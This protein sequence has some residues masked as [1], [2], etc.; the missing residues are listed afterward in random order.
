MPSY[1]VQHIT[2]RCDR[3]HYM[4]CL[5]NIEKMNRTDEHTSILS[6][7]SVRARVEG[8]GG[9]QFILQKINRQIKGVARRAL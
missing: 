7:A 1:M 4:N 9:I 8:C 5:L 2:I 3:S 6:R